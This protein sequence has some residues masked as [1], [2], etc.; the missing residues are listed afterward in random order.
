MKERNLLKGKRILIVDDEPDVLET[1]RELLHMC[2]VVTASSF[3][4][5]Q[6]L[7]RSQYFDI[8]ILDI[9]GVEGYKLLEIAKQRKVIPLMLTAHALSPEE[10]IKS[11][12]E[13]AASFVPKDRMAD[14]EKFL[15]DILLA[16][17]QGKHFWWR[18][19][20]RLASYYDEKFG[21][22]WRESDEEFW[23]KFPGY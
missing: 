22:N 20:D 17:E 2:E 21:P 12:K 16:K 5:A 19:L 10:T 18:W 14:I 13:G 4:E 3:D 9:M 6:D 11:Y 23:K 7:L 1:L 8:A 15:N